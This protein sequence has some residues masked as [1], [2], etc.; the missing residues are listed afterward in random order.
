M[1]S[2]H[3]EWSIAGSA[4]ASVGAPRANGSAQRPS[5][6][7]T[8]QAKGASVGLEGRSAGTIIAFAAEKDVA[9]PLRT[10]RHELAVCRY[11]RRTRIRSPTDGLRS[12][13][14]RA[15]GADRTAHSVKLRRSRGRY[16]R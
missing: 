5:V 6:G 9:Y 3:S 8:R 11:W 12:K 1:A 13:L 15:P 4:H 2:P 14:R 10:A 16:R 7:G